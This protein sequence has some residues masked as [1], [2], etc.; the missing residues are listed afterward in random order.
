[1]VIELHW[2]QSFVYS[3]TRFQFFSQESQFLR[4][5]GLQSLGALHDM[6]V[7]LIEVTAV[8]ED[9]HNVANKLD[10]FPIMA[11][12]HAVLNGL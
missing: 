11:W 8:L 10:Q 5:E 12:G 1:M 9:S 4:E 3:L 6:C 7:G 2:Y